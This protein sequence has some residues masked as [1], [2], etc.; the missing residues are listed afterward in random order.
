VPSDA[1]RASI[2]AAAAAVLAAGDMATAAAHAD[3]AGF[4]LVAGAVEPRAVLLREQP[5]A[6]RGGGA[7][8]FRPGLDARLV[9]QAPHTFF[10]EG[11]LALACELFARAPVRALYVET[12]HRYR[13]ADPTPD[14]AHPADVAH[15]PDSLF[16]AATE[17]LA[18][19]LPRATVVQLHGYADRDDGALAVVSAGERRPAP[20]FVTAVAAGLAAA[21]SGRVALFPD[22]TDELGAT[23]NVQGPVVR[24]AGG[25]F[26]HVEMSAAL[27][28]A[29]LADASLRNRFFDALLA[30][31]AA[32]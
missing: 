25:R 10:D 5:A 23:T 30:A 28:R 22:D 11:T 32:P 7:Y 14:G 9:V 13:A 27:R 29:L 31:L 24:G 16:L 20:S 15:A 6:R 4:E 2:R 21:V 26:V 18:A 19:A 1:D 12:A 3:T 8:V 17:G